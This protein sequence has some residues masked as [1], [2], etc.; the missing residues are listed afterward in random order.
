MLNIAV[1]AFNFELSCRA[2]KE[3]ALNDVDSKPIMM[4]RD[5]IKMED[6]TWYQAF[7][8]FNHVRG[9]TIDQI[10]IVDDS[11]WNVYQQQYELIDWLK[12]RM[13]CTS[14]VPEEFQILTYEW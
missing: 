13:D 10:I 5:T 11:R 1:V 12:Y 14:C 7:P 8:T 4:L 9:H 6:G 2:V 3:I